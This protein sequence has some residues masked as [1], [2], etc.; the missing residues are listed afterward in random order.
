MKSAR[1]RRIIIEEG[2]DTLVSYGGGV[3]IDEFIHKLSLPEIIDSTVKV[4]ERERG[5]KESEH[6]LSLAV[7]MITGGEC[8]DDL[9]TLRD[10][11]GFRA[12]GS[13]GDIPHPTTMGDFL[14]RFNLGHIR[15]LES[16]ITQAFRK[17]YSSTERLDTIT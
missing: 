2:D 11:E 12:I 3:L 1:K 4:K 13:H 8:L 7:T 6:A 17:V 5:L 9:F 10:E 15:Q 16:V 14:R